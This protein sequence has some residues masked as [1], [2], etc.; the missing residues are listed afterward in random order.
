MQPVQVRSA[1]RSAET[2]THWPRQWQPGSVYAKRMHSDWGLQIAHSRRVLSSRLAFRSHFMLQ[3]IK[4]DEWERA[5]NDNNPLLSVETLTVLLLIEGFKSDL[6]ALAFSKCWQMCFLYQKK[7]YIK[8]LLFLCSL[9]LQKFIFIT[10]FPAGMRRSGF[11]EPIMII[12]AV[13]V[14]KRAA[15]QQADRLISWYQSGSSFD[16]SQGSSQ[17]NVWLITFIFAISKE[18]E[19]QLEIIHTN[20]WQIR[21]NTCFNLACLNQNVWC[22]LRN[23]HLSRKLFPPRKF[24]CTCRWKTQHFPFFF[25]EIPVFWL[26]VMTKNTDFS[27]DWSWDRL[28]F[29][30]TV[31]SVTVRLKP[32]LKAS[33]FGVLKPQRLTT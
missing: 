14:K 26:P 29:L 7:K 24:V 33:D 31:V 5:I 19:R 2:F 17:A 8:L 13:S 15:N 10:L 12:I 16:T 1:E 4:R 30:V 9:I 28:N 20:V 32:L 22:T 27:C 18:L 23:W 21:I 11:L 6:F 25:I 3:K